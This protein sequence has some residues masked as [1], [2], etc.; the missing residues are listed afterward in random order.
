MA[1]MNNLTPSLFLLSEDEQLSVG[2]EFSNF[3]KSRLG[4]WKRVN[5]VVTGELKLIDRSNSEKI[6]VS[7]I[8]T[9]FNKKTKYIVMIKTDIGKT[10]P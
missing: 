7:E 9:I 6:E 3:L 2:N 10:L 1:V 8:E 4:S 5:Q